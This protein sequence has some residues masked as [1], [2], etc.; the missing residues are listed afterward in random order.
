MGGQGGRRAG[1]CPGPIGA[2]LPSPYSAAPS[3][4]RLLPVVLRMGAHSKSRRNP[5][6]QDPPARP[7][8]RG[9]RAGSKVARCMQVAGSGLGRRGRARDRGAAGLV[10]GPGARCGVCGRAWGLAPVRA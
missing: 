8:T 1:R 3:T 4:P 6:Q 9:W 2:W 10:A 7:S 5:N